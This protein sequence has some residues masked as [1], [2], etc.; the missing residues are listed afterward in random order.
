MLTTSAEIGNK[1]DYTKEKFEKALR[2]LRETDFSAAEPG[3]IE[4]D[5]DRIF[6]N[7]QEYVT[8]PQEEGRF[9]A[10]RRYYDIQYMA[11]GEEYLG[12]APCGQ[13]EKDG[14]YDACNDMQFY[15]DP[16]NPG[17]VYLKKGD[18]AIVSP[19]DGHKPRC[20]G[21]KPC[22]VKKVVVKILVEE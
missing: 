11:E 7:V 18:F 10:H 16:V 22:K 19:E 1:Y 3:K 4:I 8:L 21:A 5:G 15:R 13:M 17:K 12:Y 6:A 20:M 9:E 2:F 14:E